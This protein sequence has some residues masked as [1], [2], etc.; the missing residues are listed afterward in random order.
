MSKVINFG[1]WA[2]IKPIDRLL[3]S[4]SYDYIHG[5]DLDTGGRLFSQSVLWSRLSL[6][7][8]RELSMRVVMQYNDRYST[9]DID[10]LLT[11]RINSLTVFYIGSTHDYRDLNLVDDAREGWTLTERQFFMKLQYLFQL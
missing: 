10:P 8:S 9:W 7:L 11:Y 5:D 3:L 4:A 1:L 2:D 6:Q